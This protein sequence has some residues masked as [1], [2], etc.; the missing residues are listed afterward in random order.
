M[1]RKGDGGSLVQNH[2]HDVP[3][4]WI[5]ADSG[6]IEIVRGE[7]HPHTITIP[8]PVPPREPRKAEG[9]LRRWVRGLR[10]LRRNVRGA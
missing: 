4:V 8:E 10:G 2:L 9:V 5:P 3:R 7:P 1:E 6:E